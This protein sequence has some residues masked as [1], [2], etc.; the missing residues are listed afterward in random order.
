MSVIAQH[1]G[2]NKDQIVFTGC[3]ALPAV[4]ALG[5]EI[6]L[7]N[8]QGGEWPR[9]QGW[10]RKD[11]G[12]LRDG[13]EYI[14]DGPQS[15]EQ[16]LAS[17][18]K[19][20]EVMGRV[21]VDPTFR[22][23]THIH[24]DVRDMTWAEY[25]K[26]VL[27]Y[28]VFEDVF[29]D[30]CNPDRR[31]SNFCVPFQTNDWLAQ[32]FGTKILATTDRN[33]FRGAAGWPKYSGLNLQVTS[34][35]GSIEFRGS[36]AMTSEEDLTA[37][38]QRMLYLKKFVME[39]ASADHYA[40]INKLRDAPLV[41]VFPVGLKPEYQLQ[42]GAREQGLATATHALISSVINRGQ[43]EIG[44]FAGWPPRV[45]PDEFIT[46]VSKACRINRQALLD[47]NVQAGTG[48]H[49]VVS[50]LQILNAIN[51][52]NV[53]RQFTFRQ[54]AGISVEDLV[55][56]RRNVERLNAMYNFNFDLVTLS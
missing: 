51:R 6:E 18:K 44:G 1:L 45:E 41:D 36:H 4:G 22:C 19:M 13:K 55:I 7:E 40:W 54:F 46:V 56:L 14:F 17:I 48:R 53:P 33:K 38:S 52:M 27:A 16:A 43:E 24:L 50:A 21:G 8:I 29:F 25:E 37:L 47:M 35:F 34:T 20:G 12:S 42:E 15:G 28:M 11:D 10:A 39:D 49:T 30:H 2:L 9:I 26:F 31:V 23:S 32:L 3:E 5:I